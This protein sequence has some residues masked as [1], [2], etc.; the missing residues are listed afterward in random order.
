MFD[1]LMLKTPDLQGLRMAVSVSQKWWPMDKPQIIGFWYLP[2]RKVDIRLFIS[3]VCFL[4]RMEMETVSTG[5]VY[6]EMLVMWCATEGKNTP[7]GKMMGL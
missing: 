4:L 6:P 1:A 3:R 5:E 2:Y 7:Y